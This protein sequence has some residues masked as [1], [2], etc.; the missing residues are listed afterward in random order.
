MRVL[1]L[2]LV[3]SACT[4]PVGQ[5]VRALLVDEVAACTAPEEGGDATATI[6]LEQSGDLY[7]AELV[8]VGTERRQSL[9]SQRDGLT[10]TF[11]CPAGFDEITVR[12]MTVLQSQKGVEPVETSRPAP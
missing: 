6:T 8:E 7:L 5:R 12:R 1:L 4:V 2:P 11:T 3:L 9:P 10:V